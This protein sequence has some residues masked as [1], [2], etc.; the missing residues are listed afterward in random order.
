MQ[1]FG[2]WRIAGFALI[3]AVVITALAAMTSPPPGDE[4]AAKARA[5][6]PQREAAASFVYAFGGPHDDE[7]WYRS[8][9]YYPNSDHPAWKAH[10]IHFMEGRIELEIR[11]DNTAYKEVAGAQYPRR[12]FHHF[13][14]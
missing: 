8:D 11:R 2:A 10:L 3:A 14:R 7:N 6:N 12:G 13:G 1:T 9:F 5:A 4:P